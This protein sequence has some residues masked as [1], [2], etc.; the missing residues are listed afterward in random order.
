M[1]KFFNFNDHYL[2]QIYEKCYDFDP[3]V[4]TYEFIPFTEGKKSYGSWYIGNKKYMTIQARDFYEKGFCF[5]HNNKYYR[6]TSTLPNSG[7]DV[8]PKV[9]DTI[10]G[11]TLINFAMVWRDE[12]D[13]KIK[14][15]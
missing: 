5:Y 8:K 10:R 12:V 3:N 1:C 6:Y 7:L 4:Q 14:T 2:F 13:Q 11:D 15:A 9:K